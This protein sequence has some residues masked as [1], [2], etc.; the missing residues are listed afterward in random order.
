MSKEIWDE[1]DEKIDTSGLKK[2]AEDAAKNGGGDFKEVPH[3][4]YEVEVNKL[5]LKKSKK[6]SPMLSIRFKILDGDH[7]GSLIFYNQVLTSGFGIHNANEILRSMDSGVDIEFVNFKQYNSMLLDVIEAVNGNLE[8][9]LEY[10]ENCKNKDFSTY[11]IVDV[12]D[13]E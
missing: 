12:F 8:F 10:K 4:K 5:E 6:D 1:F 13:K 3:G 7:R 2:Y 9:V 11:K